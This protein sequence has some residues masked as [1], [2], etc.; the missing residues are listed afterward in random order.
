MWK[1]IIELDRSQM[2][3]W[4]MHIACWITKATNTLLEYV[5]IIALL[6]QQWLHK[7]TSLLRVTY[8]ACL[9]VK[10]KQAERE[11]GKIIPPYCA[12]I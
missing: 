12:L 10:I 4:S 9:V 6:L 1:N 3:G 2:A 11:M 8:I 7:C 5:I